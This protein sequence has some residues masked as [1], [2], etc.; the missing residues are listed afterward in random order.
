MFKG[1]GKGKGRG[2]SRLVLIDVKIHLQIFNLSA[3][4]GCDG[5]EREKYF[6]KGLTVMTEPWESSQTLCSVEMGIN[7]GTGGMEPTMASITIQHN[8]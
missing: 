5:G 1:R 8:I 4:L 6:I 3:H 2:G 7:S